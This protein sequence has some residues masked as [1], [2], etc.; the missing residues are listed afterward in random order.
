MVCTIA[1]TYL[2]KIGEYLSG[3]RIQVID[4]NQRNMILAG[5]TNSQAMVV[6]DVLPCSNS[7]KYRHGHQAHQ[8]PACDNGTDTKVNG[9]NDSVGRESAAIPME[10]HPIRQ[11]QLRHV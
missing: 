2:W 4:A 1:G 7:C 3:I 11:S 9:G 10:D 8:N 6:V 5:S